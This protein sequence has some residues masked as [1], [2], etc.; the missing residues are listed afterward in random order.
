MLEPH[1]PWIDPSAVAVDQLQ[2]PSALDLTFE[3]FGPD[4]FAILDR[5]KAAPHIAQYR[6]EKEGI[7]AT[8]QAPFKRYRDDLVVN[9]VLPNRLGFET[10]KNVFSRLLKN[11]FG[12]GGC[13]HH[14]WMA[15]Y[16]PGR[17]RLTD[18]Q[19]SHSLSPEGFT[20]GLYVGDYATELACQ[21]RRRILAEPRRFLEHLNPL[22]ENGKWR[23]S[24]YG[25]GRAKHGFDDPVPAVPAEVQH[26][27][28]LWIRTVFPRPQVLRWKG[29]LVAHALEAVSALWPLYRLFA[30]TAPPA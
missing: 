7:Q 28:G 12:A 14:L 29:A 13:H 3:G 17:R 24:L 5:L 16:R 27:E 30:A 2:W 4:A 6:T 10:E 8:I 1:V 22:L 26:A 15:F 9:W 19:L 25:K 21:A 11:D 18:V 20:V 23:F